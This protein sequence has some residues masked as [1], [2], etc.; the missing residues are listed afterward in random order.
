MEYKYPSSL[1]IKIGSTYQEKGSE[2]LNLFLPNQEKT[3]KFQEA[4]QS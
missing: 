4:I 3:P 1:L 2:F